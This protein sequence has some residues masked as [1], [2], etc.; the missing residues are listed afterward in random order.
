MIREIYRNLQRQY[1]SLISYH[2][3]AFSSQQANP[4]LELYFRVFCKT[5]PKIL[6]KLELKIRKYESIQGEIASYEDSVYHRNAMKRSLDYL[7][8]DLEKYKSYY[9]E[10]TFRNNIDITILNIETLIR[11]FE[12]NIK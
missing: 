4:S 3:E 12:E 8:E 11:N 1:Q 7:K 10:E 5:E 2:K 9:K 6:N